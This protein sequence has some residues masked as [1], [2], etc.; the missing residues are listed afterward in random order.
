LPLLSVKA[1]GY[2]TPHLN[3]GSGKFFYCYSSCVSI[4]ETC[5]KGSETRMDNELLQQLLK[6]LAEFKQ[7][8]EVKQVK[9]FQIELLEHAINR[10]GSYSQ[11]CKECEK[12]LEELNKHL[13]KLTNQNGQFEKSDW[14]EH[15]Q[16][17]N[18]VTAHL[19]KEHKLVTPG[20]YMTLYMAIGMSLG[21]AFALLISWD[22]A[23]GLS[24]G[25]LFGVVT[26]MMMDE[27]AKKKGLVI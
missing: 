2:G 11:D 3:D 13:E 12:H 9:R 4:D 21:P 26:G 20:Y 8:L 1:S 5:W 25:I 22:L 6:K 17:L 23:M 27:N 7:G 24:L 18:A 10:L 14:K 15:R 19:Q 16:L